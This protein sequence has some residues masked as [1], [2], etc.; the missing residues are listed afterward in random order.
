M[1][2]DIK[3]TRP[4]SPGSYTCY[5][6]LMRIFLTL[7]ALIGPLSSALLLRRKHACLV[8]PLKTKR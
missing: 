6:G 5:A 4:W 7:T 1:A 2:Q 3:I 8:K